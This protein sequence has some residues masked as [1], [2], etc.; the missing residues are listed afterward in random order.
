MTNE[1]KTKPE[2]S[3]VK[4]AAASVATERKAKA[5]ETAEV[6]TTDGSIVR[7]VVETD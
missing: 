7:V 5:K 2:P 3:T 6:R 1:P 4:D